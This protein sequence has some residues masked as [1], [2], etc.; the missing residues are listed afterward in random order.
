MQVLFH[1]LFQQ[2]V[3][4][5]GNEVLTAGQYSVEFEP[6]GV[7]LLL[8][9]RFWKANRLCRVYISRTGRINGQTPA[10]LQLVAS[11]LAAI[12]TEADLVCSSGASY[13]LVQMLDLAAFSRH[14][15]QRPTL[16]DDIAIKK[17][18]HKDSYSVFG[19]ID[20]FSVLQYLVI[21]LSSSLQMEWTLF[22]PELAK[23]GLQGYFLQAFLDSLAL[24]CA[25]LLVNQVRP[26]RCFWNS[27]TVS[28]VDGSLEVSHRILVH[29]CCPTTDARGEKSGKSPLV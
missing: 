18:M 12:S 27:Y 5:R 13:N 25:S 8:H 21:C 7:F 26:S 15:V 28:G 9:L 20:F 22:T 4:I 29:S 17:L 6:Q 10:E 16:F 11:L 2:I 19:R 24:Q 14:G 23:V 1:H 3:P